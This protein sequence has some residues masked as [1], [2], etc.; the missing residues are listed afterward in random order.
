MKRLLVASALL[1]S[2]GA[3]VPV[4][5]EHGHHRSG[6]PD[7]APAHGYRKKMHGRDLSFDTGLGVYVVVG[8]PGLYFWDDFYWRLRDGIWIR[9]SAFDGPWLMVPD[10]H[11]H[12]P[13]GLAKKHG[14]GKNAGKSAGKANDKS[15]KGKGKG[16]DKN[17]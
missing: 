1:V 6:P 3:C 11:R 15:D 16:K 2:L 4:L 12:L 8:S 13:P 14:Y 5:H 9:A 10:T 17:K 7:H